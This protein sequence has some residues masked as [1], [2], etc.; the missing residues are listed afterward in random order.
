MT[1]LRLLLLTLAIALPAV[2]CAQP[3]L[4]PQGERLK[5]GRLVIC[6]SDDWSGCAIFRRMVGLFLGDLR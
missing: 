1:L 5:C 4:S 6:A 2:C 3:A